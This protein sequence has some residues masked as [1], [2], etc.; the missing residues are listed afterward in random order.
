M[1]DGFL[2]DPDEIAPILKPK[3]P[4]PN[5]WAMVESSAVFSQDHV[6]R[7]EL[8]R[9]WNKD[10]PVDVWIL[11]NPSEAGE[12]RND[13]TVKRCIGFSKDNGAG[14][15]IVINLFAFI[16]TSHFKNQSW[17]R[18]AKCNNLDLIGSENRNYINKYCQSDLRIICGWGNLPSGLKIPEYE[19]LWQ[20][21]NKRCL[22]K[23]DK[24][25]PVHPLYICAIQGFHLF[26]FKEV[27]YGK[28]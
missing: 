14:G 11:C 20:N 6:Y 28:K 24:G 7:Y 17:Q 12:E 10:L 2:F 22:F 19:S 3:K 26:E 9:I 23:T 13:P 21:K 15:I 27:L 18:E 25:H 16:E 4:K 5:K 8:R 1:N